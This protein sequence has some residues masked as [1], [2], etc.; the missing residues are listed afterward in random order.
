MAVFDQID[1]LQEAARQVVFDLAQAG[2]LPTEADIRP[3]RAA[4]MEWAQAVRF[5]DE[6]GL[7]PYEARLALA[8]TYPDQTG[9]LGQ[10]IDRAGLVRALAEAAGDGEKRRQLAAYGEHLL[11][12]HHAVAGQM[13]GGR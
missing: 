10:L 11:A 9:D 12:W 1:D 4:W 5:A 13:T 6:A 3:F 2:E 7:A 8:L